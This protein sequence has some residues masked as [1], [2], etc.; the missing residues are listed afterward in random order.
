MTVSA[1]AMMNASAPADRHRARAGTTGRRRVRRRSPR[2]SSARSCASSQ[3]AGKALVVVRL[4]D[5]REAKADVRDPRPAAELPRH[6]LGERPSRA[7]SSTRVAADAPRRSARSAGSSR[8]NGSPSVVS[9]EAQTTRRSPRSGAAS[10]TL[11]VLVVFIAE[12]RA[13]PCCSPGAGIAARWTTTSAPLSASTASPKSVRSA[14][15]CC[16]RQVRVADEVDADARRSRARAGRE[17]RRGP[18]CRRRR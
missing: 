13:R 15:S 11:Y 7:R 18:P 2:G 17:R 12:G 14:T 4:H 8:S 9:L 1:A 16:P 6:L 3:N 5:V 10:K